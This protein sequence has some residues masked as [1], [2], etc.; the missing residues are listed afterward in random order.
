MSKEVGQS[1]IKRLK[2][3]KDMNVTRTLQMDETV[4]QN[5]SNAKSKES[6]FAIKQQPSVANLDPIF[7]VR[8]KAD[9]LKR[10]SQKHSKKTSKQPS[11]GQSQMLS[12]PRSEL[13]LP[14]L[15]KVDSRK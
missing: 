4:F 8:F 5:L 2:S 13:Q 14:N 12:G 9:E 7:G 3:K 10:K 6:L 15:P 11:K 1:S